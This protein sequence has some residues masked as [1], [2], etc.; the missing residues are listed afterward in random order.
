MH[1]NF[2]SSQNFEMLQLD[3]MLNERNGKIHLYVKR[4][5]QYYYPCHL[6]GCDCRNVE[7]LSHATSRK[8]E[9]SV[10]HGC[11][12]RCPQQEYVLCHLGIF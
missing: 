8:E 10:V 11:T 1:S 7:E 12:Q 9:K 3:I 2:C 6:K 5:K 4:N